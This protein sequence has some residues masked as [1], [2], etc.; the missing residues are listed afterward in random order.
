[1]TSKIIPC[2]RTLSLSLSSQKPLNGPYPKRVCFNIINRMIMWK[3]EVMFHWNPSREVLWTQ[4]HMCIPGLYSGIKLHIK[5]SSV[6]SGLKR[7]L[8]HNFVTGRCYH[9]SEQNLYHV[10]NFY[11]ET[12]PFDCEALPQNYLSGRQRLFGCNFH[13]I[14]KPSILLQIIFNC[15]QTWI[16]W[17]LVLF[18]KYQHRS[19]GATYRHKCSNAWLTSSQSVLLWQF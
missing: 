11:I 7:Y 5:H 15:S 9:D 4:Q 13:C 1:M 19:L 18:F 6:K 10:C 14:Q 2:Y 17:K 12:E 3:A 16:A 8:L